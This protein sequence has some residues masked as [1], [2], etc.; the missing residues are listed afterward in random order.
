MG[1][2]EAVK[3][4][5]ARY[6]DFGGRASR[7]EYWWFQLFLILIGVALMPLGDFADFVGALIGLLLLIPGLA[8]SVRRLHDT[9]KSGLWL[10]IFF[11][12]LLGALVLLLFFVQPSTDGMNHYGETAQPA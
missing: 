1:F 7:S 11:I 12:P 3:S 5:L 6:F 4:C 10:L 9:G 8:V 2:I